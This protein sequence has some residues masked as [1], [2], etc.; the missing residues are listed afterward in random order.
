M[1]APVGGSSGSS[2]AYDLLIFLPIRG[3]AEPFSVA[4]G[5]WDAGDVVGNPRRRATQEQFLAG[6]SPAP[7][8]NI[9]TRILR[10]LPDPNN[11]SEYLNVLGEIQSIAPLR[12]DYVSVVPRISSRSS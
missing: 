6:I 3:S 12:V 10:V 2:R 9:L 5:C 8:R 1:I 4:D 7:Q 11:W